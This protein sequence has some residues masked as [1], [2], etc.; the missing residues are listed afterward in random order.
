MNY[1]DE[2]TTQVTPSTL[3]AFGIEIQ[4]RY[5]KAWELAEMLNFMHDLARENLHGHVERVFYDSKAN[6]CT[7]EI[8][9]VLT[10]EANQRILGFALEHISQF[11]FDDVVFH[12]TGFGEA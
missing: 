1:F 9:E 11:E 12:G 7:F 4:S 5:G 6:M 8:P 3:V 2:K 10:N